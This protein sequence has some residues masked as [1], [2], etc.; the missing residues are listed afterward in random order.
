MYNDVQP[1]LEL[2]SSRRI[3]VLSPKGN[4]IEKLL[5][6]AQTSTLWQL[7]ICFLSLWIFLFWVEITIF[8]QTVQHSLWSPVPF[9]TLLHSALD[10]GKLMSMD[11]T[12]GAPFPLTRRWLCWSESTAGTSVNRKG[13]K[14]FSRFLSFLVMGQP[15]FVYI[16]MHSQYSINWNK[17]NMYII[18]K[19]K[20]KYIILNYKN[21]EKV[22]SMTII[23]K[24]KQ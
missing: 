10:L 24:G 14:D 17:Y 20:N 5:P 1:S 6:I 3:V 15:V 21:Y 9:F 16:H 8:N 22:Y 7:L 11:C 13:N 12:D 23:S 4:P 18:E 19:M 2:L